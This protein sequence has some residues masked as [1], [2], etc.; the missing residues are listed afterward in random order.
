MYLITNNKQE[1][2]L[3]KKLQKAL[4]DGMLIEEID[5]DEGDIDISGGDTK[6]KGKLQNLR[7]MGLGT[8]SSMVRRIWKVNLE[9]NIPGI[10][11]RSKTTEIALVVLQDRDHAL[12]LKI[13]LVEL[14]TS[15]RSEMRNNKLTNT[16]QDIED[17]LICTLN[18][19]YMLLTLNH[20]GTVTEY[21]GKTIVLEFSGIVG[22]NDEVIRLPNSSRLYQLFKATKGKEYGVLDCETICGKEKIKVKFIKNPQLGKTQASDA[23]RESFEISIKEVL[24]P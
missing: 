14:K 20:H 18:R 13:V 12:V 16:F 19:M 5:F 21:D 4:R 24:G 6:E 1:V 22:Y 17:K 10:S 15:L 8:L 23:E 7:I 3:R 2:P 9:K 11:T